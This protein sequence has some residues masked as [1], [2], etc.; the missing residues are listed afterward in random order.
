MIGAKSFTGSYG[1]LLKSEMFCVNGEVVTITVWPSGAARATD[2]VPMLPLAPGLFST[3]TGW[4]QR[5]WIS[6][7]STRA[8]MS[9][10]VPGVYGTTI[11]MVRP[12][13]CAIEVVAS[14]IAAASATRAIL[15]APTQPLHNGAG[16]PP[17]RLQPSDPP[18]SGPFSVRLLL[19]VAIWDGV[20]TA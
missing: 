6:S 15:T 17:E 19:A 4:S 14:G 8:R 18:I 2:W 11:V 1:T 9:G 7:P 20:P 5:C 13:C 16:K 12:D 3:T 10:P